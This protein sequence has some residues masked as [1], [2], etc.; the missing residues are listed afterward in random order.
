MELGKLRAKSVNIGNNHNDDRLLNA[1]Y[2]FPDG[3][4]C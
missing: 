3:I 1:T 2:L 4:R